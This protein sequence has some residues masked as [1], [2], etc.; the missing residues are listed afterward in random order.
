MGVSGGVRL[1]ERQQAQWIIQRTLDRTPRPV[2]A[3]H[4]NPLG[5]TVH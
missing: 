4:T 2:H 1:A 3:L 5:S